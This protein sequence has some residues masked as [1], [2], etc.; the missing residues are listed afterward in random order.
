MTKKEIYDIEQQNDGKVYLYP[1]GMFYKAYDR[2]AYLLCLL[3]RPF[4]VSVRPLKGID[5]PLLSVGFPM[6]SL[7]K[8]S[9]G[10][11]VLENHSMGG[12]RY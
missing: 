9:N 11:Q 12:V 8:F 6:M 7:E 3:V 1:E 4:K 10:A 5:G 2:S